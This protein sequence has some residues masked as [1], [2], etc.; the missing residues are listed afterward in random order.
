MKK[1]RFLIAG[2]LTMALTLLSGCVRTT[3]SGKPYGMVYDYLAKPM[4][5]LMEWF[6]GLFG[7]SYGWAIVALVVVVRLILLPL[8]MSQMKKSTMM[9]ERMAMLQPQMRAL[10]ERQKQAKT[11]EEQAAASQAMMSF[12]KDNNV[13][14]T[15]GIGCL[16][17]LIQLPVFSAL[18][19]AIRYSPDLAQASFFGLQLGQRS[20]LLAIMAFVAYLIQG[21][22]SMLG[23]PEGQKK[24]MRM[25]LMM[26][27]IMILFISWQASAGLG[28]YFFIGG[29][30][31]ILQTWLVNIYRPRIRKQI[32]EEMKK[33][34]PKPFE[35]LVTTP[36]S[37][38]PA[39]GATSA[40][41]PRKNRNAGKQH[42][43]K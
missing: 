40:P 4:Q 36:A 24:Q 12:Y 19:F 28:L 2:G 43:H 42:H 38:A 35:P 8:M 13:S 17:L 41:R 11:P 7:N 5:H 20:V 37:A 30:F 25:A 1:K 18:Y 23:V 10:Q 39:K 6:A 15:G 32:H 31:A 29:V 26:S 9:Q 34:P 16:P 14:L 21:W 22:L 33:N 3:K 27:P